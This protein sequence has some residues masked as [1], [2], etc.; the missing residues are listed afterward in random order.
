MSW[1]FRPVVAKDCV[2][3]RAIGPHDAN[4]FDIGQ[5]YADLLTAR[6]IISRLGGA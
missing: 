3:D 2:G 6:E 4:L 5:K 1:N